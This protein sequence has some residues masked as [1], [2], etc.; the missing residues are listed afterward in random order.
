M[1]ALQIGFAL[2]VLDDNGQF[3][4]PAALAANGFRQV[5]L[6]IIE[7]LHGDGAGWLNFGPLL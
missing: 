5:K 3:E 6:Y 7:A 2:A 1:P 4:G